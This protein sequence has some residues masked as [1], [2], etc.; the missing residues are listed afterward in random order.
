MEVTCKYKSIV[1]TGYT[2]NIGAGVFTNLVTDFK[3]RLGG[4]R[5]T[6]EQINNFIKNI[7]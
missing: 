6:Q 7:A 4:A 1:I 2:R 3:I 5:P